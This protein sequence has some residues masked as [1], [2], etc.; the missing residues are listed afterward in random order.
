MINILISA[1]EASGDF[2]GAEIAKLLKAKLKNRARIIGFGGDKMRAA[3]VDVKIGLAGQAVFG[4]WEVLTRGREILASF[5]KAVKIIKEEK[6]NLLVVIDYPGFHLALIKE[7]KKAGVDKVVYYIPPQVWA[8]KY[9]RIYS[10]KKYAD[11]VIVKMP[12]EE[13]VYRKAKIKAKYFGHP[14]AEHMMKQH[15]FSKGKKG[16]RTIA[17]Y[18]GSRKGE[19]KRLLKPMLEAAVLIR[20]KFKKTSFVIVK[21][22][23]VP[24]ALIENIVSKYTGL[25]P[26]I[27]EQ[28]VKIPKP[29]CAIAKSG[30]TTLELALLGIPEVVVYKVAWFDY[31]LIKLM[32]KAK[33]I[34]LPNIIAG[35]LIVRELIQGDV[36]PEN[37]S[38]EVIKILSERKYSLNI[39]NEFAKIKET[40]YK[41]GTVRD[42]AGAVIGELE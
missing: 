30:T 8:W 16:V 2:Y 1:G 21:A 33:M 9:K 27:F 34:A 40:L 23:S 26:A 32:A 36:T 15:N 41:K 24:R 10:I 5:R 3:G 6:I 28:G 19:I 29:A 38:G 14:L 11:L 17:L 25:D 37:I 4:F 39:L 18:P 13:G 20:K 7:A 12:F 22:D 31:F 42:I 35:K